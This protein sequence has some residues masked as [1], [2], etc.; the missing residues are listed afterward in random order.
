MQ[1]YFLFHSAAARFCLITLYLFILAKL[2]C[3]YSVQWVV[4]LSTDGRC[5]VVECPSVE[6]FSFLFFL[7]CRCFAYVFVS[8]RFESSHKEAQYSSCCKI[9]Y[10]KSRPAN[11]IVSL[12]QPTSCRISTLR[13]MYW[14]V[15][16]IYWWPRP[17][18]A[19][20]VCWLSRSVFARFVVFLLTPPAH[21]AIYTRAGTWRVRISLA[22]PSS[23]ITVICFH[24][25]G[26]R[27]W[28]DP[29]ALHM[30]V[31]HWAPQGTFLRNKQSFWKLEYF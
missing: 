25:L 18:F 5:L 26:R 20:S 3:L 11:W 15:F 2:I 29:F 16:I 10:T 17:G 7:F 1:Q 30:P 23:A 6:H 12:R 19:S 9:N 31:W 22:R 8:C 24:S 14:P 4:L 21:D 28:M 27:W 13:I